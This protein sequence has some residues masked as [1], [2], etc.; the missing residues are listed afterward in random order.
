MI[1]KKNIIK[2]VKSVSNPLN[3]SGIIK[4]NVKRNIA[5]KI[6]ELIAAIVLAFF[7]YMPSRRGTKQ[8]ASTISKASISKIPGLG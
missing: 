1:N 7:Q 5:P 8:P 6:I 3:E 2:G 4:Y